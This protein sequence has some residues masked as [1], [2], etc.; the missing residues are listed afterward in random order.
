LDTAVLS[1]GE[2]RLDVVGRL[3]EVR[4]AGFALQVV[5][6]VG[7]EVLPEALRIGGCGVTAR[8]RS[9][10]EIEVGDRPQRDVGTEISDTEPLDLL[11]EAASVGVERLPRG[12]RR[13]ER[14]RRGFLPSRP[15][16]LSGM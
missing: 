16:R 13:C 2:D 11:I 4:Q 9:A 10:K 5:R 1:G 3:G 14:C 15:V 12:S 6:V 8:G 7:E